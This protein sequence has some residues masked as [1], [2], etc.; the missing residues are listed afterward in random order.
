MS[1]SVA[2][3]VA[4]AGR[5]RNPSGASSTRSATTIATSTICTTLGPPATTTTV[6]GPRKRGR[7]RIERDNNNR[8]T[9]QQD[10]QHNHVGTDGSLDRRPAKAGGRI[11]CLDTVGFFRLSGKSRLLANQEVSDFDFLFFVKQIMNFK[12]I[13]KYI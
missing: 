13:I 3:G 4:I 8:E 1:N 10:P 11:F 2:A 9:E 12:M 7:K 5:H 6:N